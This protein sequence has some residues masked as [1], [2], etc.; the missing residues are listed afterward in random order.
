MYRFG[1]CECTGLTVWCVARIVVMLLLQARRSR[2][3]RWAPP[4]QWLE[5]VQ[6]VAIVPHLHE[7]TAPDLVN[8]MH[9]AWVM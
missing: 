9:G 3:V 8:T 7:F 2:V 6:T 1:L 5:E 4:R